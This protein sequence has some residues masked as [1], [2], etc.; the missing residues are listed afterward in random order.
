[1]CKFCWSLVVIL[2][3][4]VA[5]LSYKF[6][7]EGDVKVSSDN[8]LALQLTEDEKD[9]ILGEMRAFLASVQQ[10]TD[11]VV[12]DDMYLIATAAKAVG[13]STR[14][15]APGTL[16]GKLPMGFKKLGFATHAAFDQLALDAEQLGDREHTLKQLSEVMMNCVGCHAA[17]RIETVKK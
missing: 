16:V 10:I 4:A 15:Q 2:L 13:S 17:Y 3:L 11:G 14:E 7:F 8:R 5:G 1:M 6:I 12:H 9:F